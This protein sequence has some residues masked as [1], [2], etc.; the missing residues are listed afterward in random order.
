MIEKTPKMFLGA[1]KAIPII[2]GPAAY[3]LYI[4]ASLM[5]ALS[6]I[7]TSIAQKIR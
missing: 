4:S 5:D 7:I 1:L 2:L 6:P 3:P